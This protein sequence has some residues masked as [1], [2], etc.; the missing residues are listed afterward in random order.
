LQVGKIQKVELLGFGGKLEWSQDESGLKVLMPQQQ[1][2]KYA[3][4]FKVTGAV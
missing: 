2:S 4:A 1:Q 3:A